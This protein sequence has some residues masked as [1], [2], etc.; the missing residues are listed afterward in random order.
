MANE[1]ETRHVETHDDSGRRHIIAE[2]EILLAP[3]GGV[4][5]GEWRLRTED[6]REVGYGIPPGQCYYIIQGNI[7]LTANDPTALS[8][9]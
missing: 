6:D 4:R 3:L 5:A 8:D 2:R 9:Y 7:R 1:I